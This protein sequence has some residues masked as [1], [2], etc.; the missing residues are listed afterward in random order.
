MMPKLTFG[1]GCLKETGERAKARGMT[2][3]A[4]FCDPHLQDSVYVTTVK[5]ALGENG[6]EFAQFSD[7]RI[8]PD[9]KTVAEATA[10]L[11]SDNFDG[12]VSVGG[13]STIDTAK[14]AM[15]YCVILRILPIISGHQW[16]SERRFPARC[17][18]ILPA[19]LLREQ[20]PNAHRFRYC[21]S[22]R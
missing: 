13:G 15:A 11:N 5:E 2:K 16:G 6:I 21:G 20:V 17:H 7:I 8:E 14:A 9:E 3:V 1:R 22:M 10:F 19:P 18:R 4:L 12:V